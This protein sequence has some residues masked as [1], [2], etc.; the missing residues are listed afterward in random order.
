MITTSDLDQVAAL[1][2]VALLRRDEAAL[3]RRWED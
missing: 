2:R 3:R 1:F